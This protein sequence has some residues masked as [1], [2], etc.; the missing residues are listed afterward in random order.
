MANQRTAKLRKKSHSTTIHFFTRS[1]LA[2]GLL[3]LIPLLLV[4]AYS[5]FRTAR[6]STA[7]AREKAYAS[8]QRAGSILDNYYTHVDNACLFLSSNPKVSRQ[9]QQA[10]KEPSLS[11]ESL[12]AIENISLSF[13]NQIYTNDSLNSIY[14][15]YTNSYG[16]IFAPLTSKL[17]SFS[18]ENEARILSLFER[19]GETD[20]WMEFSSKPFLSTEYHSENLLICRKLSKRATGIQNGVVIYSFRADRLK[21]E[22]NELLSYKNQ[23]LFLADPRSQTIWPSSKLFSEEELLTLVSPPED[24]PLAE[25][26]LMAEGS[27]GIWHADCLHSP[28]SYGFSCLLM[29]PRT[30]IYSTTIH[31]TSMYVL[32]TCL[33]M[34]VAGILAWFKTRHDYKYLNRIISVFTEPESAVRQAPVPRS[35]QSGPFEFILMNV[36]NLFIEQNYLRIQDSEKEARLQLWKIQALQ[37][38]INPHFLHNTL[39]IIYWESIRL[40]GGENLCSQM[41]S[42][43]S[44]MMRYSLSDAQEDV[45]V[46]DEISY[47]EKYVSIMKLRYPGLFETIF[48]ISPEC[49]DASVKKM[50]LQPLVENS[51]YHGFR[52]KAGCGRIQITVHTK[53]DRMYFNIYDTGKGMSKKQ[54]SLLKERLKEQENKISQHIGLA[55]TNARLIL[56]YGPASRLQISSKEGRFTAIWFSIPLPRERTDSF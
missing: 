5:I 39:N 22:L 19:T 30:E 4:S 24:R 56:S 32:I 11:L 8:L 42:N 2:N 15:Y 10:F 21:K 37:H 26:A 6:E 33:A 9:L 29:T 23:Q 47:L 13:Q 12:R 31:L 43:L 7:E 14:I 40:T 36:I 48:F 17:L 54:L 20:A 25:N 1:L 50:L 51:I 55:N 35:F 3:L 44:S 53:R 34:A 49:A 52:E 45:L 38:Q 41:I 27:D 16:R 28:R 18:E 46:E